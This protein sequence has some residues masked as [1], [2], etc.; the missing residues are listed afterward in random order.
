M[1]KFNFTD[2]I[3]TL[4]YLKND[5]YGWGEFK[6]QSTRLTNTCEVVWALG[7][8]GENIDEETITFIKKAIRGEN[9]LSGSVQNCTIPRDYGWA[10]IALTNCHI[11]LNFEEYDICI[12][13]LI[14]AYDTSKVNGYGNTIN[15]IE[16]STFHTAIILIG[17][18]KVWTIRKDHDY[19]LK[20]SLLELIRI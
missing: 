11:E 14:K 7:V 4:N 6:T 12:N 16:Y 5:D 19:E 8:L 1:T 18:I 15:S 17:L 9:E 20:K 2:V 3:F 13:E 10:L